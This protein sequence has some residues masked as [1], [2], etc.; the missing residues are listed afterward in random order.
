MYMHICIYSQVRMHIHMYVQYMRMCIFIHI[1]L[2]VTE[3]GKFHYVCRFFLV[4]STY[5]HMY[6]I[7][8]L[9]YTNVSRY[10]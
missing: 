9:I 7:V 1:H 8:L 4:Q 2:Y 6:Q 3:V 5:V 10:V